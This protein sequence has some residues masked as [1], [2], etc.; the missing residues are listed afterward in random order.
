MWFGVLGSVMVVRD[1]EQIAPGAPMTRTLLGALLFQ[2]GRHI[3]EPR[4]IETL[5]GESP[6]RSAKA[7]LQNHVLRLRRTLGDADAERVRRSYDGYLIDV[8]PGELDLHEFDRLCRGGAEHLEGGRWKEADGELSEALSL[9]RGE[10]LADIHP[11]A[12]ACIGVE[13][14]HAA[15]LQ[16]I[17]QAADARLR[18]GRYGQ[19]VADLEPLVPDHP[20]REAMHSHLMHAL[21]GTGRQA[22]ALAVYQNLRSNLVGELGVE[23]SARVAEMH[24]QIL[25]AD[26]SLTTIETPAAA[27]PPPRAPRPGR[28]PG[29]GVPHQL[30]PRARYFTGRVAELARL[31]GLITGPAG[32]RSSALVAIVG[33]AGVGKSALA[34]QWAEEIARDFPDG[35]LYADLRGF[36]PADRP[37]TPDQV[38]R[39]FLTALDV[40]IP[41][42]PSGT[43]DQTGMLRSLLAE[44][45]VLVVLDN[46][47][48]AGQVRPLL[49]GA[50]GCLTIV[51]SRDR[52][53]GLVALDGARP[54][55]LGL[56]SSDEAVDLLARRLGERRCRS[57]PEAVRRLAELCSGL[58][59]AL[60]IAAAR[61]ATTEHLPL[62]DFVRELGDALDRLDALDAGDPAASVRAVFS[63][64]YRQLS[65][66]AALVFRLLG[67][68]P[69]PD[70]STAAAASLAAL[71]AGRTGSLIT[72]LVSAH[73]VAEIAPGR[74]TFHDLLRVYALEQALAEDTEAERTEATQRM[75]DH[76]L[77][78]A[79]HALLLASPNQSLFD[80]A[81]AAAGTVVEM[82]TEQE[83]AVAWFHTEHS[84]L[85]AAVD[86]AA[87][88]G[89]DGHAWQLA[90]ALAPILGR[91]GHHHDV[92]AALRTGLAAAYSQGDRN[93]QA[94]IHRQAAHT[95]TR[96]GDLDSAL[97]HALTARDLSV[98]L[99]NGPDVAAGYRALAFI[100][101][102][103][104]EYREALAHTRTAF[105]LYES[106]EHRA[107]M[108]WTL[109]ETAY[110]LLQ[111]GEHQEALSYAQRSLLLNQENGERF[112]EATD[113]DNLG[114][115]HHRLGDH[116]QAIICIE[117]GIAAYEEIGA[118]ERAAESL[119]QL[120]DFHVHGGDQTAARAALIRALAIFDDLG[121]PQAEET[122]SALAAVTAGNR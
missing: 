77:H 66:A 36:D 74:Y 104:N 96:L 29:P 34:V 101:V 54:V 59:L 110:L 112:G 46:A 72:E 7:S 43:A 91:L 92:S 68:H 21:H 57:A 75:L 44:R 106:L 114:T 116:E 53:T 121:H 102:R 4:L 39:G 108:T 73:L 22:A 16:L 11:A 41:E 18:L 86:S 122:R 69:G 45:R 109:G 70:V 98:E 35:C 14:L 63:C 84:V 113:W 94:R 71:P 1:G 97:E 13:H 25:A 82:F 51:T 58:P 10:P 78:T 117:R 90:G 115:I 118:R 2:A 87:Q 31:N 48:D 103:R 37:A 89:C 79:Y 62:P 81:P 8:G 93:A 19:V 111:L 24:R 40:A 6:P 3:P 107:G 88:I 27:A 32:T 52:L 50:P 20:W 47:R 60:N 95:D 30:P 55:H 42:I 83:H 119:T 80:L 61:V 12:R 23:P 105:D 67:L 100:H 64:S 56:L 76:Y 38:L 99:D 26:P 65:T 49:S 9:W 5:W 15:R 120:A 17:E 85:P 33:T 28:G